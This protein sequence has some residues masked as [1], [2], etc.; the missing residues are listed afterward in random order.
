MAIT[1]EEMLEEWKVDS[2][3][4]NSRVTIEL[5]TTPQLHSKYL[6]HFMYFKAKLAN[7]EKK[8]NT[9]AFLRKKY[10]RGEMTKDELRFHGWDQFQGLKVSTSEF[11]SLSQLDPILIPLKENI[12]IH[13][14]AVQCIEYILKEISQRTWI[15]KSIIEYEK[16]QAGV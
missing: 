11:N 8:Y 13:K 2:V 5:L 7:S 10:Y 1:L 16:F 14:T 12:E 6:V 3:V 9:M 15:L 4:D